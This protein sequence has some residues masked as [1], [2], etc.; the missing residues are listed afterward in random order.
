M[1]SWNIPC[2]HIQKLCCKSPVY[3]VQNVSFCVPQGGCRGIV[4]ESGCG[5]STLLRII[6]GMEKPDQGQIRFMGE[7]LPPS[8]RFSDRHA[9][10][11]GFQNSLDAVVPYRTAEKIVSEPLWNFF[12][13]S[14]KECD[15]RVVELFRMVG[16]DPDERYKYPYQFSGGQLQRICIAR[17]LAAEHKLL[18]LDEPL[19]SLDVSVQA[20]ILNLL[21][22]LKSSLNLTYLL[23]S[24]DLEA[25]YY[26]SDS[27]TVM[28][29]GYVMETLEDIRQINELIH[30]YS[31]KL[32]HASNGFREKY[33]E[34]LDHLCMSNVCGNGCPYA[35]RCT[36][37][38]EICYTSVPGLVEWRKG[39]F[40]ACHNCC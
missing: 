10:Q 15:A 5:K 18:L 3:A 30:P 22:D 38:K 26:L 11:M 9:L 21:L 4:G 28:Y 27:L 23:V 19:S 2:I 12:H 14:K 17:A 24:H 39:H 1:K 35:G 20:Q 16:L 37:A 7:E 8:G 29:A 25:V 32:L 40:V 34:P 33:A 31:L 13:V 36:F 6:S